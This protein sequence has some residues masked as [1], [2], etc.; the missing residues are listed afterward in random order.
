MSETSGLLVLDVVGLTPGLLGDETPNL[1]VLAAQGAC[2]PLE[3]PFPALT[4]TSQASL[5]TGLP[6]ARHGIVGN[7]WY[8]RE[9]AEVL[10]WKQPHAIL[11]AEDLPTRLRRENPGFTVA[12]LFWWF[13]MYAPVDWAVTP[14]PIPDG[15]APGAG[16]ARAAEKVAEWMKARG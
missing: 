2:G 3:C 14:R 6:P 7:G 1:N 13:N 11:Q 8:W 5:L 15:A 16:A 4:L 9:L 10:F 12:K